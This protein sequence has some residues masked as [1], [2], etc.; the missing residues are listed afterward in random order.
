M[1]TL[2]NSLYETVLKN[3]RNVFS[4]KIRNN[5]VYPCKPQFDFIRVGFNASKLHGCVSMMSSSLM[6]AFIWRAD[7]DLGWPWLT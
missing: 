6:D 4:V 5:N 1:D 3:I 7:K 2:S